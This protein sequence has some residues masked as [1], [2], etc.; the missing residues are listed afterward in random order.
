MC[1][2][3]PINL[4][5]PQLRIFILR[6]LK[7]ISLF[8]FTAGDLELLLR[9]VSRLHEL[10]EQDVT[11]V[12]LGVCAREIQTRLVSEGQYQLDVTLYHPLLFI[13][14]SR[15]HEHLVRELRFLTT[16]RVLRFGGV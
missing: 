14:D 1:M 5:Y 6:H 16:G 11:L 4:G 7:L 2:Y 9:L 10:R 8:A 12:F 13:H 15:L 3:H